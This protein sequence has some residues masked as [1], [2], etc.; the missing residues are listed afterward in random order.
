MPESE[1]GK[2]LRAASEVH[3][4]S[5]DD[6]LNPR[7]QQPTPG[8]LRPAAVLLPIVQGHDGAKL[9]LTKRSAALKHHPGQIAFPGGKVEKTDADETAAALREAEEEIGLARDNVEILTTLPRHRTITG[10]S[11]TPVLGLVKS[12]FQPVPEKGEVDEVFAVP[13]RFLARRENYSVQ[14]RFWRGRLRSYYT[15]PWG[16]YY[17]WGATARILWALA[18][19]GADGD[20]N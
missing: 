9:I 1:L 13:Y 7:V 2:I 14:A 8:N 19:G 11:V 12:P 3:V 17:I 18:N 10:F 6:D 5:S 16:P 15:V 20:P 4:D